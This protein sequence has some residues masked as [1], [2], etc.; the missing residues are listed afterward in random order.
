[1]NPEFVLLG[2]NSKS[3]MNKIKENLNQM[4]KFDKRLIQSH[5]EW[6]DTFT[7]EIKNLCRIELVQITSMVLKPE[8]MSRG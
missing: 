3:I 4:R 2:Y 8:N 5:I 7:A 1:M 6:P